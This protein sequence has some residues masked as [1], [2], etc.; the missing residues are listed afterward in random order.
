MSYPVK[1][2]MEKEIQTVDCEVSAVEASK[3]MAAK[4]DAYLIVLK[5]AQPAGILTEGDLLRKIMAQGRDPAKVKISE[6]MSTPLITIS[7][8]EPVNVAVKLMVDKNIRRLAV[9]RDSIIYGVITMRDLAKHF[10]DYN[11]RVV[12]DIFRSMSLFHV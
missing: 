11:E 12:K 9:V 6:I 8:E 1:D 10:N 7:P 3:I 4:N 5:N 2:Y